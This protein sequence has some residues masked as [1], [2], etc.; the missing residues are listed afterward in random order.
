[1][2]MV[3]YGGESLND[4]DPANFSITPQKPREISHRDTVQ[5][6]QTFFKNCPTNAQIFITGTTD[7]RGQSTEDDT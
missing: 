4:S 2:S 5:T 7:G 6:R 1:M 3:R